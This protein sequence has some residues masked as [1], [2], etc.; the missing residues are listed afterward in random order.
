MASL[1]KTAMFSCPLC[2]YTTKYAAWMRK[3]ATVHTQDHRPFWC[4]V[5]GS[6]FK[7]R[8]QLNYHRRI[9]EEP[10][11]ACGICDF[12]CTQK[13]VL[14]VHM[15]TH[16]D[17]RPFKCNFC[18]YTTKRKSDLTTHHKCMHTGR[19]RKKRREEDVAH[20]F[21][22]QSMRY[23][24]EFNLSFTSRPRK[25]ARLDFLLEVP[26]GWVIFEVDERQHSQYALSYECQRM[27]SVLAEFTRMHEG[28]KLHII[29]YNPDAFKGFHGLVI[30][31]SQQERER[32]IRRAIEHVPDVHFTITYLFYRAIEGWPEIMYNEQYSLHE[33]VRRQDS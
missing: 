2:E 9:H 1:S 30:K 11:L 23:V 22:T 4:E 29:R 13:W 32:A 27:A 12:R 25:Y 24:R 33:H 26:F 8:S 16:S 15:R 19:A 3:H 20:F 14:D 28:K 18:E 31:P 21:D 5:C 10:S 7:L 6:S 17:E